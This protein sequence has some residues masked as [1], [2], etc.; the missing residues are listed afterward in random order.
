[1]NNQTLREKIV[2]MFNR[3]A[4]Y[5][6]LYSEYESLRMEV[7]HYIYSHLGTVIDTIIDKSVGMTSA[8]KYN[9]IRN[10]CIKLFRMIRDRVMTG[11]YFTPRTL[12]D[13]WK[14]TNFPEPQISTAEFMRQ[15]WVVKCL[16]ERER[17]E[18]DEWVND[19]KLISE[20]KSL[21]EF[22]REVAAT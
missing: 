15:P 17:R 12:I 14:F 4:A 6:Y 18:Y 13:K 8:E 19:R 16:Y 3:G 10:R 2:N 9:D 22:I 7:D 5:L 11:Y 21:R 1:M 20:A